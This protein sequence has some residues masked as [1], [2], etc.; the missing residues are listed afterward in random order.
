M[1]DPKTQSR[2]REYI[3]WIVLCIA[4]IPIVGLLIA[5]RYFNI[6]RWQGW[7]MMEAV[8]T[9]LAVFFAIFLAWWEGSKARRRDKDQVRTMRVLL[10]QELEANHERLNDLI[11]WTEK[12]HQELKDIKGK[13]AT[14]RGIASPTRF[15]R[16]TV[17]AFDRGIQHGLN[18]QPSLFSKVV[19]ASQVKQI[20][21]LY[22]SYHDLEEEISRITE[23]D[24]AENVDTVAPRFEK[25][26]DQ[27]T[28]VRSM[29][30]KL[31]QDLDKDGSHS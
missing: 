13:D 15:T 28:Q 31:L 5:D 27:F 20:Y 23:I 12:S 10:E 30:D 1:T 7:T 2:T 8:G 25:W 26:L 11:E 6:S 9:I 16:T 24:I 18:E 22:A 21:E 17:S 3:P 4:I 14:L 29:S 19:G